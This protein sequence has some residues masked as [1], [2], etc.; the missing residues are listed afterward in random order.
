MKAL[1]A[2]LREY[3]A[4][5]THTHTNIQETSFTL[6]TALAV[7]GST[8]LCSH[9]LIAAIYTKGAAALPVRRNGL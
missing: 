9:W 6:Y 7:K 4:L 1:G 2:T 5:R 3:L 8:A